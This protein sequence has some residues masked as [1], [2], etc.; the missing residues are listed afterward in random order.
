MGEARCHPPGTLGDSKATA[1]SRLHSW[2]ANQCDGDWEHEFG[3]RID[4]LDNPGWIVSIDVKGTS[5]EAKVFP[6]VAVPADSNPSSSSEWIGYINL[7]ATSQLHR[8][9]VMTTQMSRFRRRALIVVV[10]LSGFALALVGYGA[11]VA[12]RSSIPV[13]GGYYLFR[14]DSRSITLCD[15][16]GYV[17]VGEQIYEI[18]VVDDMIVGR[19]VDP[20]AYAYPGLS[21][22]V[23][24][25]IVDSNTGNL[26]AGVT[27][28][29]LAKLT[30]RTPVLHSPFSWALWHW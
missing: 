25:F 11:I 13:A 3:V 9:A 20:G 22:P 12:L 6:P 15:H 1:I 18:G 2:Y 27:K 23:G 17:V 19:T 21:F 30:G 26:T 16:R 29:Q 4:T 28:E 24:Y 5:V 7:D 10:V 14:A 8:E